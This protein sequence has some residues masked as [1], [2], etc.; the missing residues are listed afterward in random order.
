[1]EIVVDELFVTVSVNCFELPTT[2]DPKFRFVLPTTRVP[3]WGLGEVGA[4]AETAWHPA[5]RATENRMQKTPAKR[6]QRE[7]R[8]MFFTFQAVLAFARRENLE[9]FP[10]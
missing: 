7:L 4:T 10:S 3:P 1:M 9:L 6:S 5:I 2:A 8:S